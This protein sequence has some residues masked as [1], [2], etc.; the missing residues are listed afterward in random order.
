M[1]RVALKRGVSRI[2]IIACYS[3]DTALF[4]IFAVNVAF[5]VE[6]DLA[7]LEFSLLISCLIFAFFFELFGRRK[8]FTMRL[9]VTSGFSFMVAF[10][11]FFQQW[12]LLSWLDF[13]NW[14]TTAF[15]MCSVSLSVPFIADFVKF[16]KRGLAYSYTALLFAV[17]L[18]LILSIVSL[19]GDQKIKKEWYFGTTSL[20]GLS[21]AAGMV[22]FW[23]DKQEFM[24]DKIKKKEPICKFCKDRLSRVVKSALK[25]I[26]RDN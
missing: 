16:K 12:W 15:T 26:K 18:V 10:G 1:F 14:Q 13:F 21:L 6:Q 17:C 3:Y 7:S 9:A 2:S 23:S 8:V 25:N 19:D 11:W 4:L 24:D 22:H 5:H 20:L